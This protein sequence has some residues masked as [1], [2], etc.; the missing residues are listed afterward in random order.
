MSDPLAIVEPLAPLP[1]GLDDLD[2]EAEVV[3]LLAR[4]GRLENQCEHERRAAV[5]AQRALLLD[6]LEVADALDRIA[7][8]N[9]ADEPARRGIGATRRLLAAKLAR[10][11]VQPIDL[12]GVRF[13]PS[14]ADGADTEL[15]SDLPE[16]TVVQEIVRGYR[17][18]SEVLRRA[19]VV[20][21]RQAMS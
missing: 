12:L 5:E 20:V 13:D 16:D 7:A 2:L 3:G 19:S 11:G 21:S 15:R 17:W 8:A 14:I 6:I 9:V 10:A 18:R 4:C 1:D